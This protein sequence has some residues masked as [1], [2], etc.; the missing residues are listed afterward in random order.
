[1]II[2][3]QLPPF[4]VGYEQ[5]IVMACNQVSD[6]QEMKEV[7]ETVPALSSSVSISKRP[8][9]L[10][11]EEKK[12]KLK[13]ER[14]TWE[15][16]PEDNVSGRM[17]YWGE[18]PAILQG[19]FPTA[20]AW[21]VRKK[22]SAA[23]LAR[24]GTEQTLC[25]CLELQE[26]RDV[27]SIVVPSDLDPPAPI[28]SP[29]LSSYYPA[30]ETEKAVYDEWVLRPLN[31]KQIHRECVNKAIE[32][33]STAVKD[34][35]EREQ[36]ATGFVPRSQT[37]M[38]QFKS[39]TINLK[40]KKRR[41][42]TNPTSRPKKA[43][44]EQE[45]PL[46]KPKKEWKPSKKYPK[47]GSFK[48][49]VKTESSKKVEN[50]KTVQ[51]TETVK[52]A[53]QEPWRRMENVSREISFNEALSVFSEL[54]NRDTAH[55]IL[56][57]A[58]QKQVQAINVAISRQIIICGHFASN[59]N[60]HSDELRTDW[61][62][63]LCLIIQSVVS[64]AL[65]PS[66]REAMA[67]FR[68]WKGSSSRAPS[69][70]YE[71]WEQLQPSVWEIRRNLWEQVNLPTTSVLG[72]PAPLIANAAGQLVLPDYEDCQLQ[73]KQMDIQEQ[74]VPK[75]LNT[76]ERSFTPPLPELRVEKQG[77]RKSKSKTKTKSPK[78]KK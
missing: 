4:F 39:L 36:S 78:D 49:A 26:D 35:K 50:S 68:I 28:W 10:S 43:R 42:D 56:A 72:A 7:D 45:K 61:T 53:K 44:L 32:E 54:K 67:A 77:S 70:Y 33:R 23:V 41:A 30:T 69:D 38:N 17:Y 16:W 22:F 11:K 24:W 71:L 31:Q 73:D 58:T 62:K 19:V 37:L 51:I 13:E 75:E 5:E 63:E 29:L 52:S 21:T 6:D 15:K 9:Q 25:E 20:S 40:S 8:S 64:P 46:S 76:Q 3:N 18:L 60:S 14:E 34:L 27:F 12:A 57:E 66:Y 1:L 59:A 55:Q 74:N 65:F 47:A 48:D 2:I